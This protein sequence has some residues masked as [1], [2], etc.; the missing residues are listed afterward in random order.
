MAAVVLAVLRIASVAALFFILCGGCVVGVLFWLEML[1]NSS[2]LS[3]NKRMVSQSTDLL[4][5][6]NIY[7]ATYSVFEGML[8]MVCA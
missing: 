5:K 6:N 1:D 8:S 2:T 4:P 7:V 3:Q